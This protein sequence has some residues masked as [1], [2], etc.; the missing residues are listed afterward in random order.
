MCRV[1]AAAETDDSVWIQIRTAGRCFTEA[2]VMSIMASLS[3]THD[4]SVAL[5]EDVRL[6]NVTARKR[7]DPFSGVWRKVTIEWSSYVLRHMRG[8][9]VVPA[10]TLRC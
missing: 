10:I 8:R 7:N 2:A 6:E 5:I 3:P 1:F 4:R 9:G